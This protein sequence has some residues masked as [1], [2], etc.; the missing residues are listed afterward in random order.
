MNDVTVQLIRDL[1]TTYL[2]DE[3]CLT[4]LVIQMTCLSPSN[5]LTDFG[6]DIITQESYALAREN[7]PQGARRIG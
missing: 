5:L 4:L 1:A 7:D 2:T 6:A 3:N